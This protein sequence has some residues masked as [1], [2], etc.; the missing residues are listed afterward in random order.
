MAEELRAWKKK[1]KVAAAFFMKAIS[2]RLLLNKPLL[3]S[4]T[5]VYFNSTGYPYTG[6]RGSAIG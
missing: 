2:L 5:Q 1:L 6:A 4:V 3:L